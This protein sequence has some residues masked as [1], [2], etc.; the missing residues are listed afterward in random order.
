MENIHYGRPDATD[1]EVVEAA[2]LAGCRDFI[3]AMPHSFATIVGDRGVQLSGGQRQRIAIARA[4]LKDAPLL[5]LDEATSALDGESKEAI[6]GAL[7]KLMQGRTVIVIAHRLSTVNNFDR[8]VVL[9]TGQVVQDGPPDELMSHEGL[10]RSLV[11]RE[12][13]RL[14]KQAA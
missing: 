8:I 9:R 12:M 14:A 7:A 11:L 1:S 2:E 4:F 13:N 10:Y 6:Q 5:L 3:E